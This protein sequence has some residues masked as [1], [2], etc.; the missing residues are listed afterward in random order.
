MWNPNRGA[1]YFIFDRT[2]GVKVDECMEVA[3][4]V[5]KVEKLNKKDRKERGVKDPEN[6]IEISATYNSYRNRDPIAIEPMP[7]HK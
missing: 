4:A 1:N 5:D 7:V 3:K 2:T 6:E